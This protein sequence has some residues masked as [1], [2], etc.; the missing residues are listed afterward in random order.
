MR[1]HSLPLN[2]V[3][4]GTLALPLLSS[5]CPNLAVEPPNYLPNLMAQYPE[6]YAPPPWVSTIAQQVTVRILGDGGS[7]SGVI[8]NRWGQTYTVLTNAHVLTEA[9][10]D[11]YTILTADERTH[12]GVRLRSI[13]FGNYDLALVQ[14]TSDRPYEVAV[15]GNS[16]TLLIGEPVYAAGFPSWQAINPITFADTRDWGMK[17]FQLTQGQIGMVSGKPLKQGYQIG[18]T[19]QID[20]GMSGGPVFDRYG[21]LIAIN[22][23]LRYPPQGIVAFIFADGTMPSQALFEQMETFNWAIPISTFQQG[24]GK[25]LP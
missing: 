17:A 19:N 14:F 16:D 4:L 2:L 3:F 20:P 12:T 25:P 6:I 21:R 15:M 10:G 1:W 11:R 5:V 24:V 8:V 23:S 13:Q 7:G 9:G 18:Y 22:G